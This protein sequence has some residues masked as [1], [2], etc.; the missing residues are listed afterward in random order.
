MDNTNKGLPSFGTK[1]QARKSELVELIRTDN[2]NSIE[3]EAEQVIVSGKPFDIM[4]YFCLDKISGSMH[5]LVE[6]AMADGRH[7]EVK[8]YYLHDCCYHSAKQDSD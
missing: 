1:Y 5:M 6:N 7:D 3:V 4:C 8:R 2:I